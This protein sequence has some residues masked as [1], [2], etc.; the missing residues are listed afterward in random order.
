MIDITK[1]ND[2]DIGRGVIY[3]PSNEDGQITSYNDRFVFVA[4]G[5][6]TRGRGEACN[7]EDLKWSAE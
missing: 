7:P 4:F 5:N 6:R 1:L 2:S 3:I